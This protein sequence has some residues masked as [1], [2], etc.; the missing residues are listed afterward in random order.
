MSAASITDV[1]RLL[2]YEEI[3]QLAARYSIY[4]DAR[5]IDRLVALFV[6]DVRVGRDRSG[7]AALKE[8]FDHSFRSVG[9]TFLNVGS[10][11]IDLEDRDHATGIV[12]CRGEIQDGGPD[13]DRWIV[14]AIQYHDQYARV[15]GHWR[16]VRRRHHLVYGAELGVNPL[17]LPPAHWPLSQT[18]LGSHPHVLETW[19]RFWNLPEET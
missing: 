19:R 5:D 11:V 12:Y 14:H 15:D 1:E 16:F 9:I 10:H 17:S 13:S 3:R 7:H 2:A 6:P 18:G 8:D 4:A